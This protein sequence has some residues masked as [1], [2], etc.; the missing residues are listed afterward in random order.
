MGRVTRDRPFGL[1][2]QRRRCAQPVG[3]GTRR[4][5]PRSLSRNTAFVAHAATKDRLLLTNLEDP[6]AGASTLSLTPDLVAGPSWFRKRRELA[7]AGLKWRRPT[8]QRTGVSV[9]LCALGSAV[10]APGQGVSV[11]G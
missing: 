1:K 4:A 2:E 9:Q 8:S 11:D 10:V 7:A 6:K 3:Q 5:T